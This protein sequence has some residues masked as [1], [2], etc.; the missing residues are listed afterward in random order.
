M[1]IY[2]KHAEEIRKVWDAIHGRWETMKAV[3][4]NNAYR[5]MT[6]ANPL[7]D[8]IEIGFAD[9]ARGC[10]PYKDIPEIEERAALSS[11]ALPNPYEMVLGTV[12]GEM[13]EIPWDFARHYCDASYRPAIEAIA[14]QGRRT[15]GERI[16]G[17]RKSA[18]LTQATLAQAANIGRVTLV[19][20]EKGEQS[21]RFKTLD[22]IARALGRHVTDLLMEPESVF[23]SATQYRGVTTKPSDHGTVQVETAVNS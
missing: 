18:G 7:E 4:V 6:V 22:A 11:L 20:L 23:L 1:K 13:V 15:L 12:G 19:R 2:T 14:L 17:F 5:M 16:R 3:L 8:S 9:G 10:I 21:P